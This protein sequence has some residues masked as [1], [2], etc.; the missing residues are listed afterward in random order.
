MRAE[1][2]LLDT[3]DLDV[4]IMKIGGELSFRRVDTVD[5]DLQDAWSS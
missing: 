1:L 5:V 3:R 4:I 2:R